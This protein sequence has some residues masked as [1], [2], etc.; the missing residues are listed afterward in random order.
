M[1]PAPAPPLALPR[2]RA[3]AA[4][5]GLWLGAVAVLPAG[6][7]HAT[8]IYRAEMSDGSVLFTDSPGH[9]GFEPFLLDKKP[10]PHRSRVNTRTFPLLD[11]WDDEIIALSVQHNVPPELI[12]AVAVAE[13]GMNPNALS[14][15]GA[16]GLMQLM[17]ATA[18]GLGVSD[19]YDPLQNLDG[20]VRYLRK[21]MSTFPNLRHAIAAYNA[22]PHNV[23]KHH[24]IPPFNETQHY[25]VRVMDLY[26]YLRMER[27]VVPEDVPRHPEQG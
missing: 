25:V 6:S 27:P 20:G 19:A 8:D 15:A 24:G 22:G 14:H 12:K 17:P 2:V 23:K 4:A 3:V 16:M 18:K 7:A 10:L 13:S 11:T 9:D 21:L 5:G 26:D 1:K